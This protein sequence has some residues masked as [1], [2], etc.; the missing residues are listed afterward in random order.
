[1]LPTLNQ[2]FPPLNCTQ[3]LHSERLILWFVDISWST[4]HAVYK[5]SLGKKYLRLMISDGSFET[6]LSDIHSFSVNSRNHLIE[7]K[8]LHRLHYSCTKYTL[9]APLKYLCQQSTPWVTYLGFDSNSTS[10]GLMFSSTPSSI[11]KQYKTVVIA[12]RNILTHWKSED[13]PSFRIWPA[14]VTN[15][16]HKIISNTISLLA[17]QL[18][19]Y[20]ATV[21]FYLSKMT[22]SSSLSVNTYIV[23]I[24]HSTV[25]TASIVDGHLNIF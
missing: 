21:L 24:C 15:V 3:T 10:S 12:K 7:F 1:M 25:H 23:H 2:C 16:L 19:K 4:F 22:W 20:V 14:T 18:L 5:G 11:G 13:V 17:L 6:N 8:V 9:L